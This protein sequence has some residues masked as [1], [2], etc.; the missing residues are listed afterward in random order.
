MIKPSAWLELVFP[1]GVHTGVITSPR[2]LT[3]EDIPDPFVSR[4]QPAFVVEPTLSTAA[5]LLR[6]LGSSAAI[7]EEE[8]APG[9]WQPRS[10]LTQ[11][12]SSAAKLHP[13]SS[14]KPEHVQYVGKSWVQEAM[15]QPDSASCPST[16]HA[17]HV[18]L[19][20]IRPRYDAA[21]WHGPYLK[22]SQQNLHLSP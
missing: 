17:A 18:R 22:F 14:I 10:I 7:V 6:S 13:S 2:S 3:R 9:I 21:A 19:P 11:A 15:R 5:L 1:T 16:V 12:S 4:K 8:V 20:L